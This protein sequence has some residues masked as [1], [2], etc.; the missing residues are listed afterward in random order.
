MRVACR[1]RAPRE[2]AP[3]VVG[4]LERVSVVVVADASGVAWN[5]SWSVRRSGPATGN[6]VVAVTGVDERRGVRLRNQRR[7]RAA[8][9]APRVAAAAAPSRAADASVAACRAGASSMR[10]RQ[11]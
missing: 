8:A 5:A 2:R 4:G 3:D 6:A 11:I 9:P 10:Q 1:R 7:V